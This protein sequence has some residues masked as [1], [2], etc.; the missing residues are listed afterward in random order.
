[1]RPL[2]QGTHFKAQR[3]TINPN[4]KGTLSYLTQ[5]TGQQ[6]FASSLFTVTLDDLDTGI[7]TLSRNI[8]FGHVVEGFDVLEKINDSIVDADYRP[9]QDI[10]IHH[11][12]ILDDP[13]PDIEG[14]LTPIESPEPS[15]DQLSTVRLDDIEAIDL[16]DQGDLDEEELSRK[17]QRDADS[18]ALTLEL[19]GDLPS[20]E[21]KPMEN[22]LF[23]CKLNPVTK[24]EDL[25]IIFSRFGKIISCEVIR[26]LKSGDSLQYAFIEFAEKTSCENAYFK[27]DGVLIDDRRIHVDFSQSVSRL[28]EAWRK[29]TAGRQTEAQL[30]NNKLAQN[31][32]GSRTSGNRYENPNG[33]NKRYKVS[34]DNSHREYQHR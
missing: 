7:K 11:T 27:M 16:N 9:L 1:V 2:A 5:T 20:A 31:R 21:L 28:S 26:D 34:A 8:V 15:K 18:K 6:A 14:M 32:C 17:K 4:K 29:S 13:F 22:V 33:D 12:I 25:K 10:R 30:K 19:I 24:D 23:V 3:N